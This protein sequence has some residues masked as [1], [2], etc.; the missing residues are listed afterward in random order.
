ML[1]LRKQLRIGTRGSRLALWQ[2]NLVK[3]KLKAIGIDATLVV[4]KTKGD[5]IKEPLYAFG[6]KGLFVKAIEDA[7]L[8]GE[9]DLAVHSL[10][11]MSVFSDERFDFCV[12]ERDDWRDVFVSYKGDIFSIEK[13]AKIGT[14]SLRRRCQ[15]YRLRNDL[16][17]TDMRG[18]LDTRLRKLQDGIVDGIVVSMAG[19]K[20]L[21]L[22]NEAYMQPLESLIPAAGQGVIAVEFL[23]GFELAD[24]IAR[25]E[26]RKTRICVDAERSFVAQLNAS[27]NYPIGAHAYFVDEKFCMDVMYGYPDDITSFEMCVHCSKS[28]IETLS[29][30]VETIRR[31]VRK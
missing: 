28:V 26:D 5:K 17:F 6:G 12:L 7:L 1:L 21:G 29:Y 3:D 18:N 8:G 11:D 25:L 19:L 13:K 15:L 22:F 16:E 4:I 20:R 2:A 30:C 14:S 27:C 31:G 23:K 10:K 24:E 9:I